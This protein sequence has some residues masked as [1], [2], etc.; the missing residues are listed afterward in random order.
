MLEFSQFSGT[1]R[2]EFLLKTNYFQAKRL[3]LKP[4]NT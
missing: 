1:K 3:T 4:C 2:T